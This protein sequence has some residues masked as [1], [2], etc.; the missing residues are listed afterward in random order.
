MLI[1]FRADY[2]HAK[3][4][5]TT[6]LQK[7]IHTKR[8]QL[9]LLLNSYSVNLRGV[10]FTWCTNNWHNVCAKTKIKALSMAREPL[11]YFKTIKIRLK[12]SFIPKLC[13]YILLWMMS[14]RKGKHGNKLIKNGLILEKVMLKC[15]K[16]LTENKK[17]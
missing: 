4:P 7:L 17:I 11:V 12:C 14:S 6:E 8:L 16:T 3:N 5:E 10:P 13:T 2:F 9:V 1:N 15:L